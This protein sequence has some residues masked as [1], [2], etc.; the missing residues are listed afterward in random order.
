MLM[1]YCHRRT[2]GARLRQ[3]ACRNQTF[4][5]KGAQESSFAYKRVSQSYVMQFHPNQFT[6][7]GVIAEHVK[8][9]KRRRNEPNKKTAEDASYLC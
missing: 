9:A 7:G 2:Q 3:F 8:A 1:Q 4:C 5:R 6:F